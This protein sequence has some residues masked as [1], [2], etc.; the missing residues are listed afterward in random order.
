MRQ[1]DEIRHGLRE[2]EAKRLVEIKKSED[3]RE[4]ERAERKQVDG[5][6]GCKQSFKV[7][8][9]YANAGRELEPGSS[10]RGEVTHLT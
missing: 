3:E 1:N 8:R 2:T 6:E 7:G 10:S 4:R 9:T 5:K